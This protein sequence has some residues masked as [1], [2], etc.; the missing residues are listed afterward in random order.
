M[1][2]IGRQPTVGNFQ[3]CDAISVVNGQAAYTM[4]VGSVNVLPETANH[5]IVSLNGVIQKPNSSFTVSGSTITFSSNLATGDVIDFIQI[6]GDVLDLGV[7]SD[8]TVTSAKI[9]YPLTTFSST[10]ID[11]NADATAI[12]IDSSERVGIGTASPSNTL[13]ITGSGTPININSTNDEVKK[14]QF[15]NSGVVQGF[16]GCSSG[17]PMRILNGSSTELMR[18]N[19]SGNVGIGTTSPA[20]TLEISKSD[21][22]NGCTLSITNAHI[23]ADWS[24]G[25]VIGTVNFRTDDTSTSQPIR[26]QIVSFDDA[27]GANSGAPNNSAMKFSVA[28]NDTLSER[29][30]IASSGK[31]LLNRTSTNENTIMDIKHVSYGLVLDK[32]NNTGT[33]FHVMF[34]RDGGTKGN[35]TSTT[36]A[37]QYNT[38]SDYRLKE[39]VSYD[40]DATTRLKELKPARFNFIADADTT[41]DGFIAHEVSSVVPEAISGEKD[42]V[43]T[44][45]KV[46]INSNGEIIANNIEQADWEAGKIADENGNTQ[47]P[48]DSTWEATKVV[49]VYQGIDQSKLVP[50]LVKTIQ[51]LEARITELE[52]A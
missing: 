21:R 6:L 50:L 3:I 4:Q 18:I 10:G 15:E 47:Y 40:F 2:Y 23:G 16:Y 9:T 17:T 22:D 35:I 30:R 11:D 42:A 33:G 46:V 41:V 37:V 51:E 44:K 45:E 25:D 52:N 27:S 34:S 26:G 7:P 14:I 13:E 36:S 8:G 39:N 28:L 43:K 5:M 38:T 20:S 12:T 31:I 29:M 1:A 49:P 19:S 48:T 24:S 32:S